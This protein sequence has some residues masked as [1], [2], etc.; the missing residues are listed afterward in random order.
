V[1]ALQQGF[2]EIHTHDTHQRNG[3]GALGLTAI[4]IE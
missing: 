4:A 1:T 3:V 2:A